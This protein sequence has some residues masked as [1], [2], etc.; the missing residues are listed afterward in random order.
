[1]ALKSLL[2]LLVSLG[3]L[4]AADPMPAFAKAATVLFQG[5]SIT[6]GA[7]R[8]GD[9][10]HVLG[11][12]Y[13]F[14]VAS[15]FGAELAERSLNFLNRGV[16]GNTVL[17]LEKRWT[18]DTLDLKPDLLSVLIGVNDNSKGVAP[19]VYEETYDRLLT[20][21]KTANP[22]AKLVLCEPFAL[23]V[24]KKAEIWDE[25][26]PGILKRQEIVVRLAAKHDAA[27]VRFQS[28]FDTATKRAPAAH[29]IW[30]GVHPTYSGHQLMAEEWVRAVRE[31]WP[32]SN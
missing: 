27:L 11:H 25:W 29:W 3:T 5:D 20:A 9:P 8:N 10:N 15:R 30:D 28:V 21:V 22:A 17:D 2:F 13:Q 26:F 14:I 32:Q 31:K 7:R 6:D 24:G 18:K 23:K 1:M 12:G 4:R 19:D 16:S